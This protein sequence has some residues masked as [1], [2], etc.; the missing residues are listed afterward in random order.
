MA[1][2]AALDLGEKGSAEREALAAVIAAIRLREPD[3]ALTVDAAENRGFEYHSG[4][5]CSFFSRGERGELG[6]GGRY[7]AGPKL[8]A[9]CA[10]HCP[11][12][13]RGATDV[14]R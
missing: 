5:T 7:L 11:A 14:R 4:V 2:L 1:E 6:R 10:D 9:G 8:D 13:L 12:S 3:L